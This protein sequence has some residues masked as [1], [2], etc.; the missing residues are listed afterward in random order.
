MKFSSN[1][2]DI[3]RKIQIIEELKNS[4]LHQVADLFTTMSNK[5]NTIDESYVDVLAD[6]IIT[7][8]LLS[9]KLGISNEVMEYKIINKLKMALINEKSNDQWSKEISEL[10]SHLKK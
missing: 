6:I 3:T 9:N 2:L 1:D 7:T 5:E 4:I 10:L 8:Y